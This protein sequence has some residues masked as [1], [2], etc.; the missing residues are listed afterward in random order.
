MHH[1]LWD[2]DISSL[3]KLTI[4]HTD[5][6]TREQQQVFGGKELEMIDAQSWER[7]EDGMEVFLI[8]VKVW[9]DVWQDH[10]LCKHGSLSEHVV[11]IPN[12]DLWSVRADRM[13]L[14]TSLPL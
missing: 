5:S 1:L 3:L 12:W 10:H 14:V 2:W 8:L 7:I 9:G 4:H 11:P 13:E 6:I